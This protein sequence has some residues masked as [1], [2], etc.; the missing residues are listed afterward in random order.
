MFFPKTCAETQE[1]N[2]IKRLEGTISST[3]TG[4]GIVPALTARLVVHGQ[5]TQIDISSVVE[6]NWP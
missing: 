6:N 3:L 1:K 5:N 2:N 4:L